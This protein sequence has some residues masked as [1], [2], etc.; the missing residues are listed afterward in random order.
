MKNLSYSKKK[1]YFIFTLY[2]IGFGIVIAL[3][4]SIINYKSSF[5]NMDNKLQQM[6]DSESSF[7]RDLLFDYISSVEMLLGA[8]AKNDLT[9]NFLKSGTTSDKQNLTTLFYAMSYANKDIMQLRYIDASGQEVIRIDR[10]KRSPELL[11]VPEHRLQNKSDR[12]YF[13]EASQLMSHQFWHSNI[14]LNMEQGKI[15]QPLRPTFRVATILVVNNQLKGIVIAN[16]LFENMIKVLENSTSFYIYLADKDGEVIHNPSN[17]SGSWSKYLVDKDT[18]YS[19]F[20]ESVKQIRNNTN[21]SASGLYS[22]SFGDLFRNT[23]NLKLIFTPKPGVVEQIHEQ[24]LLTALIIATTVLI[25]AIPLSWLISIIPSSLQAQLSDAYEKIKKSAEIIDKYVMIATTDKNGHIT[26]ISTCFTKNT[27]YT[28]DEV[29]GKRHNILKHP[30]TKIEIY[31]DLWNTVLKGQVW[32]GEIKDLNKFGNEL[33]VYSVITP[34]MNNNGEIDQITAISQNITDK[35]IIEEMAVTDSLT[36]LYNRLKLKDILSGEVSRYQRYKIDFSI[37]FFDI[38]YF[39]NINDK[40]GHQIGDEVLIHLAKV[41]KA[42]ARDTD[43]ISRWGGE[44]FFIIASGLKLDSAY[45]FADKLRQNIESE[46]F[47]IEE[48]VTISSGVVQYI[49]GESSSEIVSRAD[50][51]LYQAKNSGRNI[52]IKG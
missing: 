19:I 10:D 49:A 22:Y 44:E 17:R 4:T 47:P 24:N 9:V 7:K 14:D 29:I 40:Y 21:Y 51:A 52:V 28:R 38:D 3:I 20:P 16:L 23:E 37:I 11:I 8:I 50:H 45:I 33:W 12:Y 46:T 25:V 41:L 39:K 43:Y 32:E 30:E 6:A 5:T 36:G 34:E 31:K 1:Y 13:K 48:A 15:E 26:G 35:K 42:N 2:F 18:L 27:G